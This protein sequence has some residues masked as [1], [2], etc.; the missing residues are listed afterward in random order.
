MNSE[1]PVQTSTSVPIEQATATPGERRETPVDVF[2]DPVAKLSKRTVYL[3]RTCGTYVDHDLLVR[4]A[5]F[6][7]GRLGV[8]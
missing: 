3:C 5:R 2:F 7:G 1:F 6:H 8:R 4:H